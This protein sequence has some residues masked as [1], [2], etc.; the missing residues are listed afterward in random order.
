M[1]VFKH[2]NI[3]RDK[4]WGDEKQKGLQCTTGNINYDYYQ[5]F[6]Y[7]S[8]FDIKQPIRG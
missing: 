1:I 6:S 3:I 8:I 5:V 2:I 7:Q 4:K